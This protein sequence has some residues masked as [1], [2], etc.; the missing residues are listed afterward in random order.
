MELHVGRGETRG[1]LTVFPLWTTTT[2]RGY[3]RYTMGGRGL[4]IT[5]L[6]EGPSLGHLQVGNIGDHPALV[7][8]G[9]L[10]EGGWQH[11]MARHSTMIGVHQSIAVDVACVEHGRWGGTSRQHSRGRRATP[12]VRDS[13]RRGTGDVQDEVWA[14]VADHTR[15]F[16]GDQPN[17]TG[18][19]VRRMD[20]ESE[21]RSW[22]DLRPLPGQTGVLLGVG[23]QPLVAEIFD[24]PITLRRALS[25]LLE[26]AALDARLA[27]PV[28]T[29]G[30]RARRFAERADRLRP[31]RREAAGVAERRY[32]ASEHLD[33]ASL[34]WNGADVHSRITYVRHPLLV[35][36]A[37]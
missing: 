6:T 16:A 10:F 32:A 13:V 34:H 7:L 27:P 28:P 15:A 12:Y 4:D 29:P 31:R 36:G 22:G 37:V 33:A 5:E 24:Q 18:S 14:R 21:L 19:L 30:R 23:G 11:R 1:A 20:A 2:G 17:E 3:R 25:A 35:G 8:E 26:A 9:Q